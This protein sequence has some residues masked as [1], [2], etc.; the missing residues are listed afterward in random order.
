MK[1]KT[2]LLVLMF[3]LPTFVFAVSTPTQYQQSVNKKLQ[4]LKMISDYENT[5]WKSIIVDNTDPSSY[6]KRTGTWQT[7]TSPIGFYATNY[8]FA[9]YT[10]T[11]GSF[12]F[13]PKPSYTGPYKLY[14]QWPARSDAS[15][16][17]TIH[18]THAN[19]SNGKVLNQKLNAGTWFYIGTYTFN[20]D[21]STNTRITAIKLDLNASTTG[22]V[23]ADAVKIEWA[24]N[25]IAAADSKQQEGVASVVQFQSNFLLNNF[26]IQAVANFFDFFR[27]YK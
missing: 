9:K 10:G 2:I 6:I 13:Y 7:S 24:G 27:V 15:S 18:I 5:F 1:T 14:M 12:T 11:N 21:E 3:L 16:A 4:Q 20:K 23:L 26:F 8:E 19:G 17:V 25:P 22:A